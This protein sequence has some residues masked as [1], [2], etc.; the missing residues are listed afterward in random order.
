MKLIRARH[1]SPVR[2]FTLVDLLVVIGVLGLLLSILLPATPRSGKLNK[3]RIA[4]TEAS[5]ISGAIQTYCLDYGSCPT[6]TNAAA[7]PGPGG[8]FTY[9]TA[10]LPTTV[11]VT[12]GGTYNANNSELMGILMAV[13]AATFPAGG[14]NPNSGNARN[15]RQT[16]YLNARLAA[17]TTQPGVGADFVYRDPW[18]SP[19][20]ISIDLNSDGVTFDS[21]HR[22]NSVSAD[23]RQGLAPNPAAPAPDNWAAKTPVMVWSFGPDRTADPT[24]PATAG[25]N[26]D[27]VVSWH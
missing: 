9:G 6:S 2:G 27:N 21:F 11:T 16:V 7:N 25:Q 4:L 10:H 13:S 19:Y 17:D 8:D 15:P 22:L 3:Q 1:C 12:S 18:G 20:L 26:A 23:G 5:G 14:A 24:Q